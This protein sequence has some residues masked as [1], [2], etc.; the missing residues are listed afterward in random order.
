MSNKISKFSA[1]LVLFLGI[2]SSVS[3]A[4]APTICN[5]AIPGAGA[6]A[7]ASYGASTNAVPWSRATTATTTGNFSCVGATCTA[8]SCGTTGTIA[9]SFGD[10]QLSDAATVNGV[11]T[12]WNCTALCGDPACPPGQT[13]P[14]CNS[15]CTYAPINGA[16]SCLGSVNVP[17][18]TGTAVTVP[19]ENLP[20]NVLSAGDW[21][22]CDASDPGATPDPRDH[23]LQDNRT[24]GGGLCAWSLRDMAHCPNQ[25]TA[26]YAVGQEY[27]YTCSA[28]DVDQPQDSIRYEFQVRK[29][30]SAGAF[31]NCPFAGQWTGDFWCQQEAANPNR[32]HFRSTDPAAK[33]EAKCI[34]RDV[35]AS[36]GNL[37]GGEDFALTIV[38]SQG[39][40]VGCDLNDSGDSSYCPGEST[41]ISA[42]VHPEWADVDGQWNFA[43]GAFSAWGNYPS[44]NLSFNES[45]IG[46]NNIRMNVR[47]TADPL[48]T[49]TC[50]IP[51][52]VLNPSCSCRITS[53]TDDGG[54]AVNASQIQTGDN[55]A[56]TITNPCVN[57]APANP[58]RFEVVRN[59]SCADTGYTVNPLGATGCPSPYQGANAIT[60]DNLVP[61]AY[62]IQA[63]VMQ[64]D[65]T[66]KS[67]A[68]C[69]FLV[70]TSAS[71][72]WERRPE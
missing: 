62:E 20:P 11:V 64:D 29:Q 44:F 54:N 72:W 14:P 43:A 15:C 41:T 57:L 35:D 25:G 9:G 71:E 65:A 61:G 32:L 39:D 19:V 22:H 68:P 42:N 26:S 24:L 70:N 28:A 49:G 21:R 66:S 53:I 52:N 40:P 13:A 56:L 4:P 60:L 69:N 67:C 10:I 45:H 37:A 5:G 23:P 59:G 63:A 50:V 46:T 38:E 30:G 8:V 2:A 6:C 36:T 47:L 34:A 17:A 33:Y 58:F 31:A 48:V 1:S 51:V 55:V 7:S 12:G 27:I 16:D 18:I 3:A